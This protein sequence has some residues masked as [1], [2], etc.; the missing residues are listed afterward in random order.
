MRHRLV[1]TVEAE[2]STNLVEALKDLME[3]IEEGP[4]AVDERSELSASAKNWKYDVVHAPGTA[5]A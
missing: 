3:G 4:L 1:I 5:E 2:D